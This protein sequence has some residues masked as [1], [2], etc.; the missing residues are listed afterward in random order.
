MRLHEH[1]FVEASG[2]PRWCRPN[3][4]QLWFP[5]LR[6]LVLRQEKEGVVMGAR[7]AKQQQETEEA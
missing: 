4:R 3:Q 6:M 1:P 7:E 2:K 5:L